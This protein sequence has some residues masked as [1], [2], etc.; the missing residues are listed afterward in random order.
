MHDIQ[1][2]R[3]RVSKKCSRGGGISGTILKKAVDVGILDIYVRNLR[4]NNIRTTTAGTR[5]SSSNRI[6]CASTISY[7]PYRSSS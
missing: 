7:E 3:C 6:V 4:D 5:S 1:T 2:K